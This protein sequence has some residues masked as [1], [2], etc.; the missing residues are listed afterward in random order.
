MDILVFPDQKDG[1]TDAQTSSGRLVFGELKVPCALGKSGVSSH[2][3]EGDNATPLGTF[4]LRRVFYRADRTP[5]PKTILP[6]RALTPSDGWCDDPKDTSYNRFVTLPHEGRCENLWREDHVYDIILVMGVN[7]DPVKPGKGSALFIHLAR[8]NYA[9]TQGC[10]A[11][12]GKD[13]LRLL[14]AITPATGICIR[15]MS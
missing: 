2:K 7:D 10:I 11:L 14:K 5:A 1:A 4:P 9:P 6:L 13:M 8:K 12:S 15:E 3:R